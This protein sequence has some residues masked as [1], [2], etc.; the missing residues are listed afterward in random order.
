MRMNV[1]LI[2]GVE[3]VSRSRGVVGIHVGK[4]LPLEGC[5]LDPHVDGK[6]AAASILHIPQLHVVLVWLR[7]VTGGQLTAASGS[8]ENK[9]SFFPLSF[10]AFEST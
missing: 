7:A 8:T 9:K 10:L 4:K 3:I 2:G 6:S 1:H 5:G